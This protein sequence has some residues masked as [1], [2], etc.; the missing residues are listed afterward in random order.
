M[1]AFSSNSKQNSNAFFVICIDKRM[2]KQLSTKS[3]Q[4]TKLG[5]G[6]NVIFSVPN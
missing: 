5:L 3:F 2:S 6:G 1:F 4:S